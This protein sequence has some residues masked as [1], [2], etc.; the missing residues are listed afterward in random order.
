MCQAM[1]KHLNQYYIVSSSQEADAGINLD[2]PHFVGATEELS[3]WGLCVQILGLPGSVR[4][5]PGSLVVM[6]PWV[7]KQV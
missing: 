6:A 4:G 3:N 5:S 1:A 7:S 2:D